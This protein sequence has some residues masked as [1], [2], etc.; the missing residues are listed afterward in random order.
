MR[1][2]DRVGAAAGW[3]LRWS[4]C[5]ALI[6]SRANIA[7]ARL[8]ASWGLVAG[9]AARRHRPYITDSPSENSANKDLTTVPRYGMVPVLQSRSLEKQP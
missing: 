6:A 3:P 2:M 8:W 1:K 5:L 4:F 9:R 7:A